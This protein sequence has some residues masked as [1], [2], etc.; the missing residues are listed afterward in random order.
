MRAARRA[1]LLGLL[2]WAPDQASGGA[3]P[4]LPAQ[5][6]GVAFAPQP[7]RQVPPDLALR[8]E[9]GRAVRL[10]AFLDQ[11]PLLLALIYHRC[12]VLCDQVLGRLAAGLR[13]LSLRSGK[14]FRVLVVSFDPRD[15]AAT[16]RDKKQRALRRYGQPD[17]AGWHMLTGDPPALAAL[18]AAV[19]F[20][21]VQDA[22]RGQYAH[23]AGVL[24]LTPEGR[25]SRLLSGVEYAPRELR[26]GLLDAAAGGTASPLPRLLFF[27]H[28]YDLRAGPHGA[29][30]LGALRLGGAVTLLALAAFQVR[31][32]RRE[33]WRRS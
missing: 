31:C 8:D 6:R 27:C 7:G 11:R 14:D 10:G 32:R 22:A 17:A 13:P 24:L 12:P 25:I 4:D 20:S 23:A 1:L 9:E 2:L 28:R 26:Q 16:A 5:L 19:G 3:T 21:P 15:T 29:A 33:A 30:I 18:T